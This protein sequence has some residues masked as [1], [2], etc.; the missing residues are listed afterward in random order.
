ML[1]NVFLITSAINTALGLINPIERFLQTIEQVQSI[2]QIDPESLIILIDNSLYPLDADQTERILGLVDYFIYIGWR[3]HA[4]EFNNLGII[5]AS[6][7]YM[8]LVGLDLVKQQKIPAKRLFKMSGRRKFSKEF[9][10]ATYDSI[11]FYKKYVFKKREE[12]SHNLGVYFLHTR[13]WSLCGTLIDN[14]V[15]LLSNSLRTIIQDKRLIEQA[16]Y[17]NIDKNLLSELDQLGIEG[18]MTFWN[19]SYKD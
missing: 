12:Y 8:M 4:K 11:E 2:K 3:S 18:N 17:E 7:A 15:I 16:I 9:D 5:G 13:F 6:E 10:I 1:R 14:A 19:N